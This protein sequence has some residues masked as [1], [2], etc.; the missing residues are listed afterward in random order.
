MR[1]MLLKRYGWMGILLI[2]MSLPGSAASVSGWS[3]SN[4]D[5][6][7]AKGSLEKQGITGMRLKYDFS[8]GGSHVG[9]FKDLAKPL[10]LKSVT[11]RIKKPYEANLALRVVD[12]TG[13]ML[14]EPIYYGNGDWQHVTVDMIAF[15]IHAGGANDGVVH[16]PLKKVGILVESKKLSSPVG[17]VLLADL[18][19]NIQKDDRES[20]FQGC[21]QVT[22]FGRGIANGITGGTWPIDFSKTSSASLNSSLSLLGSPKTLKLTLRGGRPGYVLKMGLGSHFQGFGRTIGILDGKEQ[23]FTIPLPPGNGWSHSGGQNDGEVR[24]PLRISQLTLERGTGPA[25]AVT[26]E[27]KGITCETAVPNEKVLF[28]LASLNKKKEGKIIEAEC[29]ACNLLPRAVSGTLT[30]TLTDWNRNVIKRVK[31]AQTLP[32]N[33]E[34]VHVAQSF[35]IPDDRH[36]AEAQFSFK[37][38]SEHFTANA[39]WTR[40]LEDQGD[41]VLHPE[42]PWGM[43]AYLYRYADPTKGPSDME[44]I[45]TMAQAAGVKWSREEFSWAATEPEQ[46]KFDFHFYDEVVNTARRHG[47]S[48]YGLL[49]YWSTWTT[50]YTEKG[51]D[52]FCVWAK[53]VV[54]HFKDRVKYWEVYNEPNIFFWQGPKELYPVL[55]KK[56][57]AAIKEADPEAK[58]LGCSTSGI[59]LKFIDLCLEAKAPFDVLTIHPY[60]PFL[61]EKD[62]MKE[63]NH[64]AEQVNGRPVWITEMGWSTQVDATDEPSQARLLA[65]SYLSAV[66]S[67]SCQSI[68]WYD[69]RDDM[70]DPFYNEANFGILRNDFVPKPAYRALETICKSLNTGTPHFRTDLGEGILALEMGKVTAIWA[71]PNSVIFPST[72]NDATPVKNLMG[73]KVQITKGKLVLFRGQ[74]LFVTGAKVEAAGTPKRIKEKAD[75]TPNAFT[76]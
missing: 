13:Q 48:V 50:P 59:D 68:S 3:F 71:I 33:G 63:L 21:Y 72:L 30:A 20:N 7:E 34:A 8:A 18:K 67:G 40:P 66:A 16:F 31:I 2:V 25:E 69:F 5:A 10:T 56:C 45:A 58:V 42:L 73:E 35:E 9:L 47:I 24:N 32:A 52:E 15:D 75:E 76:F 23:T 11:F 22:D 29:T 28:G 27:I 17:E 57:Y 55:L 62:F 74:P 46:G 64:V 12:S 38:G 36:F 60:R 49:S 41:T 1:K 14:Q 54:T 44:R 43:G 19:L 65:R 4:A 53:A 6:P 37:A 61:A 39:S 51:I 26:I 70:K